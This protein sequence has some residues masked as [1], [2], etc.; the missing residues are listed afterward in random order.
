M[1]LDSVADLAQIPPEYTWSHSTGI[2]CKVAHNLW[3]TCTAVQVEA[4]E[5][6]SAI[7]K[8]DQHGFQKGKLT[9]TGML[10]AL[11]DWARYLDNGSGADV[12]YLGFDRVSHSEFITKLKIVGVH[13]GTLECIESF[14]SDR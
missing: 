10:P 11:D 1:G 7:E 12:I 13:A 9:V 2:H 14:L 3:A 8:E 4:Y 6:C 5:S